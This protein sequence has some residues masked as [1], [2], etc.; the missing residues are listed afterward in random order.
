MMEEL[1]HSDKL[2]GE[3]RAIL[4]AA[5]SVLLKLE[6]EHPNDVLFDSCDQYYVSFYEAAEALRSLAG[7]GVIA[8]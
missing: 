2:D 7:A 5:A 3:D 1:R 6:L 4:I 8:T